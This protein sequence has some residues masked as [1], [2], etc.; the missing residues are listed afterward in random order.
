MGPA[1]LDQSRIMPENY[2]NID[3]EIPIPTFQFTQLVK[4][5][6]DRVNNLES[7]YNEYFK[8]QQLFEK[9]SIFHF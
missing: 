6:R 8:H 3:K 5:T 9:N 4:Q 2:D 1:Q 7:I